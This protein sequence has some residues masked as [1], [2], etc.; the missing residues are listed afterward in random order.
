MTTATQNSISPGRRSTDRMREPD[1]GPLHDP[2]RMARGL[3]WFSIGLGLAQ[4]AAPRRV[5]RLIGVRGRR[6]QPQH[7]CSRIGVREIASGVGDP[8]RG[9]VRRA[10]SGPASAAT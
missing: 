3:G 6:R 7:A 1:Q 8:H 9:R 2:E 5:A 10:R 4:I